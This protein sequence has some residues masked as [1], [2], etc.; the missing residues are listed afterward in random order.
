MKGSGALLANVLHHFPY[1]ATTRA[2]RINIIHCV[3]RSCK[4]LC[5][6]KLK[7]RNDYE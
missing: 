6:I 3:A 1:T 4:E 2:R 7:G 5:K